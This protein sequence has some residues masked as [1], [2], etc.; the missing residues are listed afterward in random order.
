M[1]ASASRP[2][3]WQTVFAAL[4]QDSRMPGSCFIHRDFQH[5]NFLWRRGRLTG[6]VDWGMACTGPPDVDVGHCRLNLA[7]LFGPDVAER[8]GRIYEAEAG[9]TI[10][11]WWDLHELAS[12]DD[13][14]RR[15]IPVQVAG[16]APVDTAGMTARV[17]DLLEATMRRF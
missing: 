5:Y 11:P 6:V 4:Q 16:R 3:L 15:F 14:W 12:Y 2:K 10:D 13:S 7:V 8:F 1:P 9:R 17:E